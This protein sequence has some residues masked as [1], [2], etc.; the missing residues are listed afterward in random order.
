VNLNVNHKIL[1]KLVFS[2][3]ANY[4][5]ENRINAPET[6][7][8]GRNSMNF[9][10][11]MSLAI[12]LEKFQGQNAYDP[13]TGTERVTSGF[14]GTLLNPYYAVLAGY[15]NIRDSEDLMATGTLR[16]DFTDWLIFR[17]GTTTPVHLTLPKLKI[18]GV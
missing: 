4:S 9:L 6:G 8:Q 16:Y 14:Q 13:V 2:L 11:R 7:G 12:P 10:T 5:K 15:S 3:S 1:P 17:A 18:R